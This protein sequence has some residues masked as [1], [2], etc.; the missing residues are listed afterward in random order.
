M[1][2]KK[3]NLSLV[4]IPCLWSTMPEIISVLHISTWMYRLYLK[5]NSHR[6][7]AAIRCYCL[8]RLYQERRVSPSSSPRPPQFPVFFFLPSFLTFVQQLTITWRCSLIRTRPSDAFMRIQLFREA[9]SEKVHATI[10]KGI[11]VVGFKFT[12]FFR[13][14]WKNGTRGH[15]CTFASAKWKQQR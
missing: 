13:E 2:T 12:I 15:G 11:I 3:I 9:F 6:S 5:V 8:W 14:I 7:I 10:P 4:S 1:N